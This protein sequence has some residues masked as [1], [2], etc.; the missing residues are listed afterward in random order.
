MGQRQAVPQNV[1]LLA[2]QEQ[3]WL[4][5]GEVWFD[6]HADPSQLLEFDGIPTG[7]PQIF[8]GSP[9]LTRGLDV[10]P[11]AEWPP[12]FQQSRIES[13]GLG[14]AK[15]GQWSMEA[16][17]PLP[18]RKKGGHAETSRGDAAVIAPSFV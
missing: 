9:L 6:A 18:K 7:Q 3:G 13:R 12:G 11:Q 10:L 2:P 17:E 15:T 4:A 16:V 8:E 14:T 1:G 5:D